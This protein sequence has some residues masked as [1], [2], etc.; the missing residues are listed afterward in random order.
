MFLTAKNKIPV[1]PP[2]CYICKG[3]GKIVL[4]DGYRQPKPQIKERIA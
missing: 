4:R 2:Q 3:A 1:A